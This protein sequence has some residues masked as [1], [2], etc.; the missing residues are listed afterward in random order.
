[1]KSNINVVI[2][3]IIKIQSFLY[4]KIRL[5]SVFLKEMSNHKM[6]TIDVIEFS[7]VKHIQA[8][9]IKQRSTK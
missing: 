5:I 2:T 6:R 9:V 4:K 7:V 8:Q 1:M 3:W